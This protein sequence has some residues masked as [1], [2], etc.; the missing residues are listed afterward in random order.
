M[1]LLSPP[2]LTP[3]LSGVLARFRPVNSMV[4]VEHYKTQAVNGIVLPEAKEKTFHQGVVVAVDPANK[5]PPA[6]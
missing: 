1:S 2:Q 6:H 5:S 4:L 3:A